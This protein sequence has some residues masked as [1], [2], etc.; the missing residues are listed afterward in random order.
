[1]DDTSFVEMLDLAKDDNNYLLQV[2]QRYE[3]LIK[4]YSVVN[5]VY[6]EDLHSRLIEV[7]ITAIKKFGCYES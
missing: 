2:I 3:P 6:H 4:K 1:M 5:G 7:T